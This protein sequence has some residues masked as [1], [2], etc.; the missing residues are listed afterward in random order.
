[1]RI[2]AQRQERMKKNRKG[3]KMKKIIAMMVLAGL[4]CISSSKAFAYWKAPYVV[5][6]EDPTPAVFQNDSR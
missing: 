2:I 6:I 3:G 1:M 4:I 5:E